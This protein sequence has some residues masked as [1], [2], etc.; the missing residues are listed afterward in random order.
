MPIILGILYGLW[1]WLKD[2][3][4]RK[5]EAFPFLTAVVLVNG[6]ILFIFSG[7]IYLAIKLYIFL[8]ERIDYLINYINSLHSQSGIVGLSMNFL[9]SIGFF[10]ALSDV[11]IIFSPFLNSFMFILASVFAIRVIRTVRETILSVVISKLT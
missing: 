6:T 5:A 9:S 2:F 3:I 8:K 4:K 7:Y 11:W 10:Q 1:D